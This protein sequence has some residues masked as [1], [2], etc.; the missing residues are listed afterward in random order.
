M[1]AA[2]EVTNPY[3]GKSG[4]Q[5]EAMR[6]EKSADLLGIFEKHTDADGSYN[7]T[8]EQ[9]NDVQARHKELTDIGT[10]RDKQIKIEKIAVNA[11]EIYTELNAP[12][13]PIFPG[14]QVSND[15][16]GAKSIAH[17]FVESAQFK[18]YLVNKPSESDAFL[19]DVDLKTVMTSAT[20]WVPETTR[21]GLVVPIVTRPI[22]VTDV[23]PT[24]TTTQN[25]YTYMEETTYTNAAAETA[26]GVAKPEAALAF[27][28][29]TSVVRKIPV[30]IAVTDEQLED[31]PGIQSYIES[32]L[33]NMVRQR[34]DTEILVGNGTAPNLRGIINVSGI[35]TQAKGGDPTPDAIYKAMTKIR[36]TG[37]GNGGAV[38]SAVILN[39]GDWQEIRLLTTA[40][41]GYM[42]GPPMDTAPERIWGLPVVLAEGLTEGTGIVGDFANY[43]LLVERKQMTIKVGFQNDDFIKNQKSI[44]AELRV[45]FVIT[46]PAAFATVTGI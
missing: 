33:A 44:I 10:E 38:P 25:A 30:W 6:L 29:R 27:T 43:S 7:L 34:L 19:I 35:Q 15:R 41:G 42:W 28:V 40:V 17:Q 37:S 1:A 11:K 24:I 8:D 20:G 9:L 16:I 36:L 18:Q 31:V 32:R 3:K 5:L 39:P 2:M 21:S 14:G 45:A 46:R 26:E 13:R 23:I 4:A 12:R 22:Q